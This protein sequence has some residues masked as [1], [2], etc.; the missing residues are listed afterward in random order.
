[1]AQIYEC[2]RCKARISTRKETAVVQVQ[3]E[4]SPMNTYPEK[5]VWDLCQTCYSS[6]LEYIKTRP[7]LKK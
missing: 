1:M 2:D 7:G 3:L 4:I 5:H 6:I